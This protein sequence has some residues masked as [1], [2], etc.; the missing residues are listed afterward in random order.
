MYALY[1]LQTP[2]ISN[3]LCNLMPAIIAY[4]LVIYAYGCILVYKTSEVLIPKRAEQ[5]VKYGYE[6]H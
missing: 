2:S 6:Y 5:G 4:N 1:A 3:K